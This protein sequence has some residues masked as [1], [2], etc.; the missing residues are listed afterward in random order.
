M[1]W[2]QRQQIKPTV[3]T[4]FPSL[5]RGRDINQDVHMFT[6]DISLAVMP[7][8]GKTEKHK[9][10]TV[11]LEGKQSECEKAEQLIA[12]IGNYDRP[13][14]ERMVC[15]AVQEVVRHLAYDGCA[16]YEVICD[17]DG[18]Q[19]IWGFTSKRLWRLPGYFLQI[20]PRGDW[21]LWNKKFVIVP[22]DRIWYLEMPSELGGRRDYRKVLKRLGN[23]ERIGPKFWR[24]DLQREVQ[25]KNFDYQRYLRNIDI[26]CHTVT[27][28]WGWSRRNFSV[29]RKTEF[30]TY[31][32]MVNYAWAKTILREHVINEFN[33][34]FIRLGIECELK[35][36][37]FCQQQ[38]KL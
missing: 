2:N 34:F 36:S 8:G 3:A 22:A 5:S 24:Q 32:K 14:L 15:G 23:F 38:E 37:G 17:D 4:R 26:Y 35:V 10:F 29:E 1:R 12:D 13:N 20:I 7:I 16:V 19:H 33:R 21:N 11:T 18:L 27:K 31:Y 28:T 25:I 30:F 6:Q 9:N